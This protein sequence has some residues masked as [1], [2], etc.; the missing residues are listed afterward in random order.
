M[1]KLNRIGYKLGLAGIL[2]VV[3]AVGMV[4]N[5]MVTETHVT[6]SSERAGRSQRVA[7]TSIAAHLELRKMQLTARD[8]RLARTPA[9][10]EKIV[11]DLRRLKASG[12]KDIDDAIAAAQKPE[13]RS[14]WATSSP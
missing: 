8:V 4:A 10:I 2:S 11:A 1:I 13:T 3:L 14:D 12:V 7:D 6:G 5:Q 9:E